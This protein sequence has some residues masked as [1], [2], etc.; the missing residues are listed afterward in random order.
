M[1]IDE[2]GS[3]KVLVGSDTILN[4]LDSKCGAREPIVDPEDNEA[5]VIAVNTLVNV[6]VYLPALFRYGRGV[7]VDACATSESTP[8]PS[9]PLV[10]FHIIKEMDIFPCLTTPFSSDFIFV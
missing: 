2:E 10:C 4:F 1:V 5:K 6:G 8:R 3:E 7:L 9:K